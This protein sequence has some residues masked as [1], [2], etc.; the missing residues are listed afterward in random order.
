MTSPMYLH[1][2]VDSALSEED[3]AELSI[4][5]VTPAHSVVLDAP[6]SP[7]NSS[8][9]HSHSTSSHYTTP[10][11][12]DL[13]NIPSAAS[14]AH[15]EPDQ[16]FTLA[17][18]FAGFKRA[19][20]PSPTAAPE[21][22]QQQSPS[23]V[24]QLNQPSSPTN[25][26][27]HLQQPISLSSNHSASKCSTQPLFRAIDGDDAREFRQFLDDHVHEAPAP[28]LSL[29]SYGRSDTYASDIWV[30]MHNTIRVELMDTFEII[31]A[32][33]ANY[34][35]LTLADVHNFR[36]WWR[37][38][39]LLWAEYIKYNSNVLHP[40]VHNICV[41]DGRSD[42]LKKR[43]A[44]LRA[45]KEWLCLKME[46]ITSYVEEFESLPPARVLCLIC[47]NVH[48]FAQNV[49][50]YFRG[51]EKLLP[52]FIESYHGHQV[53]LSTEC[54]L[55]DQLRKNNHFA[56]LIASII[57]WIGVSTAGSA[58]VGHKQQAKEREKWLAS[59]LFWLERPKMWYFF[60]RYDASHRSLFKQFVTSVRTLDSE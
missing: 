18:F 7:T 59:H 12:V 32:I 57:R 55:I 27:R 46:E 42:V 36:Q 29:A 39:C 8:P 16:P 14:S 41:V 3:L 43:L 48:S 25:Q 1:R 56:E 37:F 44:P 35:S 9:P 24:S 60:Q 28:L 33:R 30:I 23:S 11:S 58:G 26:S 47:K 5:H 31:A 13:F 53:K 51:C 54:Q 20:K 10:P 52:P 34:L 15:S 49:S 4:V 50:S 45:S 21:N 40:I 19:W 2:S 17:S 38:F 22:S 6:P